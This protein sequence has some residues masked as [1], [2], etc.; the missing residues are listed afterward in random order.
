MSKFGCEL[1]IEAGTVDVVRWT[2]DS[3]KKLWNL[4][5]HHN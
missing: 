5:R 1:F 3:Q 4:E 2:T